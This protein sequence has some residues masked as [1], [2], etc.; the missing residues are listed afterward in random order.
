MT[1]TLFI[2]RERY[3]SIYADIWEYHQLH[4]S[5][6]CAGPPLLAAA[7]PAAGVC[8]RRAPSRVWRYEGR[9]GVLLLLLLLLLLVV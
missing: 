1:P 4:T 7:A 6:L 3:V 5:T 9:V 2:Y 8:R